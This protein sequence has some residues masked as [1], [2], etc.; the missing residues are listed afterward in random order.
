MLAI[1][2]FLVSIIGCVESQTELILPPLPY[3]YNALEPVLSERALRLHHDKH[4][5]TY[6]DQTNIALRAMFFNAENNSKLQEIAQQPIEIILT[7]LVDIPAEYQTIIRNFGGGYLNHRLFFSMLNSPTNTTD[8]NKPGSPLLE[9]IENSFG[10]FD[11]F[12]EYF[13][14]AANS[15]FGSGWIWVHIDAKTKYIVLNF[16]INQDNPLVIKIE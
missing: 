10:S 7:K 16:T 15:Y 6:T 8:E 4:L 2:M 1:I 11:E 12:K 14:I 13:T 3:A 9:A 5:Q